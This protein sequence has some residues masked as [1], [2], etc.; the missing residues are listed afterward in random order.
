MTNYPDLMLWAGTVRNKPFE[1]RLNAARAGGFSGMS[2]S[3]LDYQR[4]VSEGL[5]AHDSE[6]IFEIQLTDAGAQVQGSLMNDL[7]HTT[8]CCR[9]RGAFLSESSCGSLLRRIGG[10]NS[11]GPELFSDAFN[12]LPAKEAGESAGESVWAL[13]READRAEIGSSEA[14]SDAPSADAGGSTVTSW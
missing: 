3:P 10:L 6:R 5:P 9:A 11:V 2:L 14:I 1:E 13:F 7:M 4:F 8:A 12:V